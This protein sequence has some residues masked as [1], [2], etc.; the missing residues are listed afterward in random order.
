MQLNLTMRL[1]SGTLKMTPLTW[2]PVLSNEEPPALRRKAAVD[3]FLTKAAQLLTKTGAT[4]IT[5][6]IHHPTAVIQTS[7]VERFPTDRHHGA[8]ARGLDVGTSGQLLFGIRPCYPATRF[9]PPP[10]SVVSTQ[11]FPNR[12]GSM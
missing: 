10:T 4:T 6:Q 5:L 3:K 7:Y 2:L 8:V 12:T 11:P 9:R 1:I